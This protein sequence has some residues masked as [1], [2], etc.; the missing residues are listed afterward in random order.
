MRTKKGKNRNRLEKIFEIKKK[1][2]K[3]HKSLARLV[4]KKKK[5]ERENSNH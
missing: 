4:G 1:V 2:K 3:T 5:R